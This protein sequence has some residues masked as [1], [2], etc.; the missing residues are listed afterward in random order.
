MYDLIIVGSGCAGVFAAY[1]YNKLNPNKK[2]LV[3]DKGNSIENRIC[4]KRKTGHCVNCKPC[5]ITTGFS[6]AGAFSDGKISLSPD[7]GGELADYIGYDKAQEMIN[8][9]D[10]IYLEHG[11]DKTVHGINE[12]QELKEIKQAAIKNNLKLVKCPVRHLGTEESY[13]IYKKIEHELIENGVEFKFRTMVHDLVIENNTVYGI[14]VDENGKKVEYKA[15]YVIVAVGREGSE[16][17]KH[18]CEKHAIKSEPS[19]VDIGVRVEIR[20]EVME[21]VNRNLYEGKFIFNTP[22]FDDKVR[23]FCQNPSGEVSIERYEN[24]LITVNGHSYKNFKT[25][26][27]NLALLVSIKFTQPF[28]DSIGYGKSIAKLANTIGNGTVLIQR[29]GDFKRHRRST[30]ERIMRGNIVPTLKD[31]TAGDLTLV[32]PYRITTDIIEMIEALNGVADGFNSDETIL[33]GVE[34]KFYNNK[35]CVNQNFETTV[36]NL[37]VAGDGAGITRGIAQSNA[38]GV[39]IARYLSR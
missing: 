24:E 23:T 4:P 5:N 12:T 19:A 31:A 9:V 32:L 39:L 14:V 33:Y 30:P 25:E 8:Y 7:V 11:A 20:D 37:F 15:P 3:I 34:C 27:T 13:E 28:N 16:W 1:E 26:N 18:I 2:I 36:K 17:F 22:T 6:G 10:S 21:K 29:Y 35:V 38:N